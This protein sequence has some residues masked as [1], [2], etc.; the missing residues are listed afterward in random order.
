MLQAAGAAYLSDVHTKQ[1]ELAAKT[2]EL[3]TKFR[4]LMILQTEESKVRLDTIEVARDAYFTNEFIPLFEK[5]IVDIRI[6][7]E[8]KKQ[9]S[10]AAARV[11]FGN[12]EST[13]REELQQLEWQAR[14]VLLELTTLD[15]NEEQGRHHIVAEEQQEYETSL[16]KERDL[17]DS[18]WAAYQ[19]AQYLAIERAL[20]DAEVVARSSVE[21]EESALFEC[22]T[23]VSLFEQREVQQRSEICETE[24]NIFAT[25][26][27]KAAKFLQDLKDQWLLRKGARDKHALLSLQLEEQQQRQSM[28]QQRLQQL[29]AFMEEAN[30]HREEME[31]WERRRVVQEERDR[32]AIAIEERRLQEAEEFARW[33]EVRERAQ[34]AWRAAETE[35]QLQQAVD[36][37]AGIVAALKAKKMQLIREH[38]MVCR[39][40]ELRRNGAKAAGR[41]VGSTSSVRANPTTNSALEYLRSAQVE[42]QRELD[43]HEGA[44]MQ[45]QWEQQRGGGGSS[46]PSL[47]PPQSTRRSISPRDLG[48]LVTIQD[49]TPTTIISSPTP[50]VK[51]SASHT[52]SSMDLLQRL[53]VVQKLTTAQTFRSIGKGEEELI[54]LIDSS[55]SLRS[56]STP[57]LNKLE[58]FHAAKQRRQLELSAQRPLIRRTSVSPGQPS[59]PSPDRTTRSAAAA[60]TLPS[61][62]AAS[63]HSSPPLTTTTTVRRSPPQPLF[64]NRANKNPFSDTWHPA[65]PVGGGDPGMLYTY[66]PDGRIVCIGPMPSSVSTSCEPQHDDT[67]DHDPTAYHNGHEDSRRIAEADLTGASG[68]PLEFSPLPTKPMVV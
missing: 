4:L 60:M 24:T 3:L 51:M 15:E 38:M 2:K 11:S 23:T 44:L 10:D 16:V 47:L 7:W 43:A 46:S 19:L 62:V 57:A 68:D 67:A 65:Q 28:Q 32:L 54:P 21:Q 31:E 18:E 49:A 27:V 26:P 35:L 56:G 34:A 40:A 50:A 42:L 45:A 41:G 63:H 52:T 12:D 5:G 36:R 55:A 30:Q 66:L 9:E 61:V 58:R 64:V 53:N 25:F 14:G 17:L 33:E 37:E 48:P 6:A 20:T 22:Y 29:A 39:H 13:A 8:A 1:L 59:S